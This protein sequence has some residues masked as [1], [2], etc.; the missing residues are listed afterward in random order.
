MAI[1]SLHFLSSPNLFAGASAN[2]TIPNSFLYSLMKSKFLH[3]RF[4]P[5]FPSCTTFGG[6][7]A[8]FWV[9]E[10]LEMVL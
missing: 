3:A 4:V 6:V 9:F 10:S 8:S 5:E 1:E 7:A 2:P